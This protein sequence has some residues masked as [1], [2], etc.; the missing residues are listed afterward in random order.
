MERIWTRFARGSLFITELYAQVMSFSRGIFT[1]GVT[2]CLRYL[3]RSKITT[4]GS[5]MS[6][7][8]PAEVFPPGEFLRD[9][10]EHRGWTQTEFAEIIGRPTRV[11][12]EIIAAKRSVTPETARELAAAIGTSAQYWLNLE[13]A[14]QLARTPPAD[15]RIA[16]EA[17][18]R[19][20]FPVREMMKRGWIPQGNDPGQTEKDVL[21]FF[22]LRA[23]NDPIRFS[24][25]ARRN[26]EDDIS[27][28]G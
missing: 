14:Y 20:R 22:E 25:A 24:H 12:N 5:A 11:V 10:L 1:L 4:K 27:E 7:R 15:E 3:K 28:S 13:S 21:E 18:L 26:Y 23:A 17:S 6:E 16:R 9:I 2:A 8:Y 19:A